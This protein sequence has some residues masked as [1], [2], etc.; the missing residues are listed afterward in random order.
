MNMY[1]CVDFGMV[2]DVVFMSA[3]DCTAGLGQVELTYVHT[4]ASQWLSSPA[5]EGSQGTSYLSFLISHF[6][7][8]CTGVGLIDTYLLSPLS[9]PL[10]VFSGRG[11][12]FTSR[13]AS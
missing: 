9:L 3:I 12:V 1:T 11:Y 6:G 7:A 10:E 2:E 8:T 5:F 13:D 4:K